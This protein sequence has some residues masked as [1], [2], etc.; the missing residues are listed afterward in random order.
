MIKNIALV[1]FF[2]GLL[3]NTKADTTVLNFNILHKNKVV[4]SLVATKVI[5]GDIISYH[6]F[7]QIQTKIITTVDL[8]YD[9]NVTFNSDKLFN[10]NVN[11]L[12]NGK[13]LAETSTLFRNGEYLVT[14]NKKVLKLQDSIV[15]ST[16]LLY[17]KEPI[18]V[19]ECYSEQDGS[20]NTLVSLG[21]HKYKKINSK[22]NENVYVYKNGVL[23]EA[24]IDG[25]L[26]NFVIQ[27]KK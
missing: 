12:L 2:C 7:T 9:Y 22:G 6:S 15:Y 8:K 18:N 20:F 19:K 10:S 4:G 26:I 25:G 21:N 14:K 27:L 13:S 23:Y 17:F 1:L 16:V 11:I 24:T 3:I 5:N